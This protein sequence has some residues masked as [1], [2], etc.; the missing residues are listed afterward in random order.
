MSEIW[1]ATNNA[2]KRRELERLL[3][4]LPD[5]TSI[6]LRTPAEADGTF[7]PVEDQPDFRGNAEI[8]SKA[9]AGL[10]H[11]VTLADDSGLCIDALDGR[12]GVLSA[13]YGSPELDD[14]GR[15]HHVL[16]EMA[17]VP[18]EQRTARFVCHLC[19]CGPDGAVRMRIEE[20]CAGVIL[21][22]PRGL[23]GFGYDPI[24]MPLEHVK[25]QDPR[26]FAE[27]TAEEKDRL[28]HRG[29]ALFELRR[30]IEENPSLLDT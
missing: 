17:A 16:A 22:E 19:L 1:I 2:K 5:G 3:A 4:S 20:T 9:L 23:G 13:R 25:S 27:L 8:K 11:G 6:R 28:S 29:K 14:T 18:D 12:P 24:F 26:S 15:L 10:V 7:D 30:A 21:R